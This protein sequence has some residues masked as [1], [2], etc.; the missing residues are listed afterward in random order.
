MMQLKQKYFILVS[1]FCYVIW[2]KYWAVLHD[3]NSFKRLLE[4]EA[5][6]FTVAISKVSD[7][8]LKSHF[9]LRLVFCF[10]FIWKLKILIVFVQIF[11]IHLLKT[12]YLVHLK[13]KTPSMRHNSENGSSFASSYLEIIVNVGDEFKLWAKVEG[14]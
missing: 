10:H 4:N 12:L 13:C 6:A 5:S 7:E 1:F 8:S 2:L 9:L 14:K 11:F 3:T